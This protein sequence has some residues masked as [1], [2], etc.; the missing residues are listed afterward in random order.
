MSIQD[1]VII[2]H[3]CYIGDDVFI[4]SKSY[5]HPNVCLYNSTK[6]GKGNIIHANSVIGSDGLGFA[7]NQDSWEKIEHL[8]FVEIKDNV[9]IGAACTIDRAS[10]GL[11]LIH[12]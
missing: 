5:L 7:K 9:E 6:L 2:N 3:G 12:I 1:G 10:L 11:S 8:G 4:G